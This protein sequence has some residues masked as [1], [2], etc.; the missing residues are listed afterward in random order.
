[1]NFNYDVLVIGGGA[2]GLL[3][4]IEAG[5][6]GK[7]VCL[8]EHTSKIGEKIRIS[9]GGKCNFTN[10]NIGY[11]NFLSNNPYFCISA[12]SQY[13]QNDFVKLVNE[14]KINYFEKKDGQLFCEKSSFEIINMLLKECEKYNVNINKETNINSIFKSNDNFNCNSNKGNF[15]SKSLV[16]ATGGLSIPKIGATSFGYE[17]AKKFNIKIIKPEPGLV[18]LTFSSEIL[19]ICKQLAGVSINVR[20]LLDKIIFSEGLLFTHRGISG[21]AILQISSYWKKNKKISINFSPDLVLFDYIKRKK[22]LNSKQSINSALFEI[23]PKRIIE[24]LFQVK[25]HKLAEV[26]DNVIRLISESI[27][28]WTIEPIGTEGFKIAEVTLGGIDTSELSSKT[29]E[30]KKVKGLYFIGEV[31]DVTGH[32]GGYNFQWAWSSGYVAGQNV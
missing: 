22:G 23:L 7:K 15:C 19:K 31:V 3:C 18:P 26:S 14:Y 12:L 8:I 20:V 27:N 13:N 11:K 30:S 32:L 29:M 17:V 10:L 5:K 6:R 1:M 28:K 16:I 21:P 4:A 9:G 25:N 2:A 24:I